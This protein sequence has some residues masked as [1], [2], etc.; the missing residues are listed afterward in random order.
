MGKTF[1]RDK[2]FRPKKGGRVFSK[3]KNWKKGKQPPSKWAPQDPSGS[4]EEIEDNT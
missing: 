3:D 1:R 2:P 4:Y